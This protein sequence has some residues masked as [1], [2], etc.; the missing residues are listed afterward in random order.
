MVAMVVSP[1]P[2]TLAQT[3]PA[4]P[5]QGTPPAVPA[6]G[7][8]LPEAAQLALNRALA[9]S[10]DTKIAA[11]Q[12][13][14]VDE[15]GAPFGDTVKMGLV[16][17]QDA[18]VQ[19]FQ[20][21]QIQLQT[22]KD[23][24]RGEKLAEIER[25]RALAP[26]AADAYREMTNL[27][28]NVLKGDLKGEHKGRWENIMREADELERSGQT[29]AA[30]ARRR[31]AEQ[32]LWGRYLAA[33]Q[34]FYRA[35]G[36]HPL[37]GVR[38]AGTWRQ[39]WLMDSPYFFFRLLQTPDNNDAIVL[40]NEHIDKLIAQL[41][42]QELRVANMKT[43]AE[44]YELG[45]PAFAATQAAAGAAGGVLTKD[46]V[47]AVTATNAGT[48]AVAAYENAFSDT[49]LSIIQVGSILIPVAGPFIS[50]GITS[51]QV[52][53]SGDE[54]VIALGEEANATAGVAVTGYQAVIAA[55]DKTGAAGGKLLLNIALAPA[56]IPGLVDALKAGKVAVRRGAAFVRGT[57][58]VATG[59]AAAADAGGVLTRVER[60]MEKV[61]KLGLPESE[62]RSAEGTLEIARRPYEP[63]APE[64]R[65]RNHITT[66]A[67]KALVAVDEIDNLIAGA[68]AAGVPEAEIQAMLARARATN[69][70]DAYVTTLSSDLFTATA[71]RQGLIF[72]VDKD[73]VETFRNFF[74]NGT[75]G[76]NRVIVTDAVNLEAI[77]TN[78]TFLREGRLVTWTPE[79]LTALQRL[80]A[81]AGGDPTKMMRWVGDEQLFVRL[82]GDDHLDVARRFLTSPD[83]VAVATGK[84]PFGGI[85][86]SALVQP[87]GAFISPQAA[88]QLGARE[89]SDIPFVFVKQMDP[90]EPL[91][92]A[93]L[94]RYAELGDDTA[95]AWARDALAG[96]GAVK[97]IN[98]AGQTDPAPSTTPPPAATG[99]TQAGNQQVGALPAG[100]TPALEKEYSEKL[101]GLLTAEPGGDFVVRSPG[102]TQFPAQ[103]GPDGSMLIYPA[104]TE[105]NWSTFGQPLF[106]A[107]PSILSPD[108]VFFHP[109]GSMT[110]GGVPMTGIDPQGLSSPLPVDP[111]PFPSAGF[112]FTP[113]ELNGF[114]GPEYGGEGGAA[115]VQSPLFLGGPVFAGGVFGA[116]NLCCEGTVQKLIIQF[117]MVTVTVTLADA[118]PVLP[119]FSRT[120]RAFFERLLQPRPIGSLLHRSVTRRI[121]EAETIVVPSLRQ[122]QGAATPALQAVI[123]SL[124]SSQGE[125]FQLDIVNDGPNSVTVSGDGVVVEPLRR[126]AANEARRQLQR[127][128]SRL[129]SSTSTKVQGYCLDYALDPPDAG[130][131]FRIA[132]QASQERFR[133]AAQ[134]LRAAAQLARSGGLNP[135]SSPEAYLES[136]KQYAIWSRIENWDLKKFT[137][138]WITKTRQVAAS[139]KTAWT[140]EMQSALESAAPGRWR[141]IQSILA[142]SRAAT[143]RP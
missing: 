28:A 5:A 50:A 103:F 55:E 143:A 66:E 111:G 7:Q 79:Q 32:T 137:V 68:R 47:T 18:T 100:L 16:L 10:L 67:R 29:A 44:L 35:L 43:W 74:S 23:A 63:D 20:Q 12:G 122:A 59:T 25:L 51:V 9:Q 37:L 77:R 90:A 24:P 45:S 126:S 41:K 123:T 34:R 119:L 54:Y 115:P 141:D 128:S 124:G 56:E 136:I 70:L 40:L 118:A 140:A 26:E 102:G 58:A 65:V 22:L 112:Q 27:D 84:L 94:K 109:D 71:N 31:D 11:I 127:L 99:A 86:P 60:G 30:E 125:A 14:A 132:P 135:D 48:R 113:F 39:L 106:T 53:K 92:Q 116:N 57:D 133:P 83:R 129:K 120:A 117:D 105:P 89:L 107:P 75:I 95:R 38:L 96:A 142:A 93:L 88:A 138:S 62:V 78:L 134:V 61:R 87:N 76:P 101:L 121:G 1:M 42:E 64:F 52:Y 46:L 17:I 108:R 85:R 36:R 6:G 73:G 82:F 130:M 114:P 69:T 139:M 21:A 19:Q 4:P 72:I 131:L 110:F 33:R 80:M 13:P 98:N 104:G 3:P 49:A 97:G 15:N 81:G 91:T 2:A 8:P